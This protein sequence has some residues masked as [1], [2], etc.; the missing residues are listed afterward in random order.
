M[1]QN[2]LPFETKEFLRYGFSLSTFK[3]LLL[4]IIQAKSIASSSGT[5]FLSNFAKNRVLKKIKNINA[6]TA[7]IPHGINKRFFLSPDL[8]KLYS[9]NKKHKT[10]NIIYVSQLSHISTNGT[11]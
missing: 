4:R 7:I 6:K 11:L 1:N 3:F 2:L 8:R 5:I 9:Q 10:F